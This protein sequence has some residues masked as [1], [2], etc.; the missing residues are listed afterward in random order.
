MNVNE[1]LNISLVDE[2]SVPIAKK[3]KFINNYR[4]LFL[5]FLLLSL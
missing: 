2:D 5:H 1:N 3:S 4:L